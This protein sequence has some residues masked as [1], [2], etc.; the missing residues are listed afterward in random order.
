MVSNL[1]KLCLTVALLVLAPFQVNADEI[2][3]VVNDVA[4]K[5]VQQLPMDKKIALKSLS[6]EETGLPD[7]FLRK[8]V[9]DFEASLLTASSFEIKLLNRNAT[10][11]IWSDAIEFGDSKFE[12]IYKA[13]EA[14]I[15]ILLSP[16]VSPAGLEI[17]AAAYELRGDS[18]GMLIAASGNQTVDIDL[19]EYLGVNINTIEDNIQNILADLDKLSKSS[20]RIEDPETF[21]EFIH[22]ARY[23]EQNNHII[24][25]IREYAAA[26]V[27]NSKFADPYLKIAQLANFQFGSENAIKFVHSQLIS[28]SESELQIIDLALGESKISD[29]DVLQQRIEDPVILSLWLNLKFRESIPKFSE[30]SR[31]FFSGHTS[32]P[33]QESF[34]EDV[35][36]AFAIRVAIETVTKAVNTGYFSQV[37]LDPRLQTEY[38]RED[39]YLQFNLSSQDHFNTLELFQDVINSAHSIRGKGSIAQDEEL[40]LQVFS[41]L[42][43][44]FPLY[45][46]Y[47]RGDVDFVITLSINLERA[48]YFAASSKIME[49]LRSYVGDAN[50]F[51]EYDVLEYSDYL[52]NFYQF[53]TNDRGGRSVI[54]ATRENLLTLIS[55]NH[56]NSQNFLKEVDRVQPNGDYRFAVY[57]SMTEAFV[58][59][60]LVREGH[61]ELANRF[62][63]NIVT[64]ENFGIEVDGVKPDPEAMSLA[65]VGYIYSVDND[66]DFLSI[67]SKNSNSAETDS[68]GNNAEAPAVKATLTCY[69]TKDKAKITNVQN[70]TNLQQQAG[71]EGRVTAQISLGETVT[72]VNRGSYLRY[73]RCAAACEGSNQNAI[74]QC[75][76]NNDVWIEVQYNGR[77]GFISRK[78]LE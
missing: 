66:E 59:P 17:D 69:M 50:I 2:T 60:K 30:C 32:C 15:L 41:P 8:L 36:E 39:R 72:I 14:S 43:D 23:S 49:K 67:N 3:D 64:R 12:E 42:I 20:Q 28:L 73:E 10:E 46:S 26:T 62:A 56:F 75:I 52:A 68:Q 48:G 55:E 37:F 65:L 40:Q 33:R 38:V 70:Y 5:L 71:S 7:E 11:E 13:S 58:I 57:R 1:K 76:D 25:A 21:S 29:F 19:Q 9:S 31:L 47:T 4:A 6:P 77:T 27:V 34:V 51:Y 35:S 18:S 78:F 61:I 45:N 16:R 63:L 24:E 54:L 22:N 74:K 44:R 53:T